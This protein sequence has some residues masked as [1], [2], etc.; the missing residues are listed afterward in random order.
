[1]IEK[2]VTANFHQGS[3]CF[4]EES[5]GR[6]CVANSLLCIVHKE[7][8]NKSLEVWTPEDTHFVLQKGDLMYIHVRISCIHS[9]LHPQDLPNIFLLQEKITRIDDKCLFWRYD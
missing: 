1:M 2:C 5:R 3:N 7:I 9:Y 8:N 4:S 6:Q